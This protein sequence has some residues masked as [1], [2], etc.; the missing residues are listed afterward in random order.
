MAVHEPIPAGMVENIS[1]WGWPQEWQSWTWPGAE[2]KPLQVRVFSHSPM[3]RLMLNGKVVGEQIIADT[4]ITAV[5][6]VP[7]QP[8]TLKAVNIENGKETAAFELKTAGAPN[9]I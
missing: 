9:H 8:G 6:E 5:F 7:Y 1:R 4:S 2:G 3:V